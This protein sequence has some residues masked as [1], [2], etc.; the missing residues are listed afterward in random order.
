MVDTDN[1][2]IAIEMP[3]VGGGQIT[4][5]CS[6]RLRGWFGIRLY[7]PTLD[8]AMSIGAD[9]LIGRMS[10]DQLETHTMR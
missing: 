4:L 7:V 8:D 6:Y 10:V 2:K 5:T 1:R 9:W 3:F